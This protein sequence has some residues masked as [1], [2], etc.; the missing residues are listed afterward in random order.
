MT[1]FSVTYGLK[2]G[3]C[4]IWAKRERMGGGAGSLDKESI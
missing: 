1:S 3:G 4:K 2:A